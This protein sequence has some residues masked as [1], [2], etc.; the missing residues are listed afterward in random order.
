MHNLTAASFEPPLPDDATQIVAEGSFFQITCL[1]PRSLPPARKWWL[2]PKGH[3]VSKTVVLIQDIFLY[4]L[5]FM[6]FIGVL[7]LYQYLCHTQTQQFFHVI[8]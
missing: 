6:F 5:F 1:E 8:L 7:L 4:L 2:N 3:I